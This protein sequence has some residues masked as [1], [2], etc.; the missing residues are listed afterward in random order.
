MTSNT[1]LIVAIGMTLSF[2]TVS[3]CA[4]GSGPKLN[5]FST[6]GISFEYPAGYSVSDES[7]TETQEFIISRWRAARNSHPQSFTDSQLKLAA[8]SSTTSCHGKGRGN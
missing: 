5:R 7:T 4:Q 3:V 8:L 6:E 2:F 1:Q